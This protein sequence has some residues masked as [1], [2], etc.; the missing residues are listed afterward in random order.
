MKTRASEVRD[1]YGR[2]HEPEN[3]QEDSVSSPNYIAVLAI[4]NAMAERVSNSLPQIKEASRALPNAALVL[5]RGDE[6]GQP[7]I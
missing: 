1:G 3:R 7:I 5:N 2:R 6:A 4:L